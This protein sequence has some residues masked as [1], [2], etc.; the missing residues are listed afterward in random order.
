MTA[1]NNIASSATFKDANVPNVRLCCHHPPVFGGTLR[2]SFSSAGPPCDS[3]SNG[4][5]PSTYLCALARASACNGPLGWFRG[6][7][8][9][10]FRKRVSSHRPR[11]HIVV[12]KFDNVRFNS[13]PCSQ[14]KY[15][16]H[17]QDGFGAPRCGHF[18]PICT[19]H[20]QTTKHRGVLDDIRCSLS[21]SVSVSRKVSSLHSCAKC[22]SLS[23]Q[24]EN[25]YSVSVWRNLAVF[26]PML[27]LSVRIIP[28][29]SLLL[30]S[31]FFSSFEFSLLCGAALEL[32]SLPRL[33]LVVCT[34]TTTFKMRLPPQHFS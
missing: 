2:D 22:T 31:H 11:A 29:T 13:T 21:F 12:N 3:S 23:Y 9:S 26:S 6:S 15:L 4:T 20:F 28:S 19:T 8:L 25:E 33:P 1:H 16:P 32:F 18:C 10:I 7:R 14:E 5:A 24:P 27:L 34:A 30:H 17:A